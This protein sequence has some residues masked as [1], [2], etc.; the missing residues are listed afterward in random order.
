ME[1]STTFSASFLNYLLPPE[2]KKLPTRISFMVKTT[3]IDNQYDLYSSTCAYGSY[4]HEGVG[5]TVLYATVTGII[6]LRIIISIESAEV[7]IIL[8]LGISNAFQS[9]I[10][11]SPEENFYPGLPHLYLEWFK[12]KFPK[13]PLASINLK[14]IYIQSI[15]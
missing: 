15:K 13:H 11:P 7:L 10:L 6:S 12:I 9:I 1:I 8:I 5:F 4:V 3:Y 2:T 14:E